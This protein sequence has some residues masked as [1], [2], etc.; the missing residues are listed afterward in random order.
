MSILLDLIYIKKRHVSDM[1]LFI[2]GK[3]KNYNL[4]IILDNLDFKLEALFL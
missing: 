1:P 3:D 2:I 4:F